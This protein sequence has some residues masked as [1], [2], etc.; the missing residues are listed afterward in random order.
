SSR[1]GPA[2]QTV[3]AAY[4]GG[5][6]VAYRGE[7]GVVRVLDAYC[8]HMGADLGAGGKVIGNDIQCPFHHWKYCGSGEGVEIPYAKKIPAKAR[9]RA[10][11]VR[12]MNG[13]LLLG[14]DSTGA[15]PD[16]EIPVIRE[17]GSHD[18]LPWSEFMYSIKTHPREIIENIADKGLFPAV[19]RTEIQEFSVT[20][21]RHM[22]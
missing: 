8:A 7:D 12:E 9:Q 16:F 20:I 6:L 10:W 5:R 3:R 19:H 21:D 1:D 4:F 2:L 15:A 13:V 18:W 11:T 22:A 14:H 17:C